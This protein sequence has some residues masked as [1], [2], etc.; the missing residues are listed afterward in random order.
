MDLN[1]SR[2]VDS[3]FIR[4]R[5]DLEKFYRLNGAIYISKVDV[6]KEKKSFYGKH[7]YAYIMEQRESIDIDSE[8][9]FEYVEFLVNKFYKNNEK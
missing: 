7:S 3:E 5:Q 2:F 6:L 1:L 4:R 9:D 8:L